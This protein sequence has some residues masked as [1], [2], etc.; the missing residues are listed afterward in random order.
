MK[1]FSVVME[2]WLLVMLICAA[3]A[4]LSFGTIDVPTA[5]YF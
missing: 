1:R 5:R 4:L 3:L 2:I